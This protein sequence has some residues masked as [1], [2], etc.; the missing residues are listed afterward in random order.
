M[1][2]G[3]NTVFAQRLANARKM[4]CLLQRELCKKLSIQ[5]STNA[6]AKMFGFEKRPYFQATAEN[7]DQAPTTF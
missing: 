6:I 2:E 1:N 4:R 3:T 7:A 5:L